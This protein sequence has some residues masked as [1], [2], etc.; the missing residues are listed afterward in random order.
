MHTNC[1]DISPSVNKLLFILY[2]SLSIPLAEA[3]ICITTL[4]LF[5]I[6]NVL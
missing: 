1:Y 4:Y 3:Q 2:R 5:N 6:L